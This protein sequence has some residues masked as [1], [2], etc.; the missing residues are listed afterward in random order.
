MGKLLD[1]IKNDQ[2]QISYTPEIFNKEKDFKEFGKYDKGI[3]PSSN[4]DKLRSSNQEILDE[5]T[6]T[7][8][9]GIAKI[10]FAIGKNIAALTD[11]EDFANQD[12]EFGNTLYDTISQKEKELVDENFPVHGSEQQDESL[13]GAKGHGREWLFKGIQDLIGSAGG[14]A[15][16]GYGIGSGLSKGAQLLKA[17]NLGDKAMKGVQAGSVLADAYL[18]NH[19]EGFGIASDVYKNA[20]DLGYTPEKAVGMAEHALNINKIN[21]LLNLTAANTLI[22]SSGLARQKVKDASFKEIMKTGLKESGQEAV[23]ENINTI[24]EKQA[25]KKGLLGSEYNL[26]MPSIIEDSFSKDGIESA[27]LGA[28]GGH[29]QGAFIAGINELNGKNKEQREQF[30]KQKNQIDDLDALLNNEKSQTL[31]GV[32]SNITN[33]SAK[34]NDLQSAQTLG[35]INSE[36]KLKSE[37]VSNLVFENAK[38]GTLDNLENVFDSVVSLNPE[39]G[40]A[41]FGD[42]YKESALE[43]KRQLSEYEKIYNETESIIALKGDFDNK[44]KQSLYEAKVQKNSLEKQ[45]LNLEKERTQLVIS[46]P[47]SDLVKEKEKQIEETRIKLN[48]NLQNQNLILDDKEYKKQNKEQVNNFVNQLNNKSDEIIKSSNEDKLVQQKQKLQEFED[49]QPPYVKARNKIKNQLN[50]TSDIIFSLLKEKK[51]KHKNTKLQIDNQINIYKDKANKLKED[52][53]TIEPLYNT[54]LKANEKEEPIIEKEKEENKDNNVELD[55]NEDFF[56]ET[57]TQ[58]KESVDNLNSKEKSKKLK[59]L[60]KIDTRLQK[61][62]NTAN[63][64]IKKDGTTESV[65]EDLEISEKLLELNANKIEYLNSI[66][67]EPIKEKAQKPKYTEKEITQEQNDIIES[68]NSL[69][70][71]LANIGKEEDIV[72]KNINLETPISL[73]H[74]LNLEET[75]D[76]DNSKQEVNLEFDDN[77]FLDSEDK[78]NNIEETKTQPLFT[79]RLL[80]NINT[81]AIHFNKYQSDENGFV[82]TD[83]NNRV[84]PRQKVLLS[85]T[86]QQGQEVFFKLDTETKEFNN[87]NTKQ[88]NKSNLAFQINPDLLSDELI[89]QLINKEEK[90][91][92]N[93]IENNIPIKIF[94]KDNQGNDIELGYIHDLSYIRNNRVASEEEN[95]EIQKQKLKQI[96]KQ[97]LLNYRNGVVTKGN[98]IEKTR[99]YLITTKDDQGKYIYK[100]LNS[101]EKFPNSPKKHNHPIAF[102]DGSNFKYNDIDNTQVKSIDNIEYYLRSDINANFK[103]CVFL[104]VPTN[105]KGVYHAVFL[106]QP[107]I[108]ELSTNEQNKVLTDIKQAIEV[109]F[110]TFRKKELTQDEIDWKNNFMNGT[111]KN[112]PISADTLKKILSYYLPVRNYSNQKTDDGYFVHV[113]NNGEGSVKIYHGKQNLINDKNSN[114]LVLMS[115]NKIKGTDKAI[116]ENRFN[117]AVK[118]FRINVS[119]SEL[120]KEKNDTYIDHIRNY[121]QTNVHE[122]S[123]G[124]GDTTYFINPMYRY[125]LSNDVQNDIVNKSQDISIDTKT[126]NLLGFNDEDINLSFEDSIDI[127]VKAYQQRIFVNSAIYNVLENWKKNKSLGLNN[128]L[129]EFKSNIKSVIEKEKTEGNIITSDLL[130]KIIDNFDTVYT[131]QIKSELKILGFKIDENNK[132]EE[133]EQENNLNVSSDLN[134]VNEEENNEEL[135]NSGLNDTESDLSRSEFDGDYLFKINTASKLSSMVRSFLY[136]IPEVTK[137]ENGKFKGIPNELKLNSYIPLTNIINELNSIFSNKGSD[138]NNYIK[139]LKE[140]SLLK[141]KPYLEL[142]ANRLEKSSKQLQN[143]FVTQ[144]NK[145]YIEFVGNQE[146]NGINRVFNSNNN[147][148]P[149]QILKQFRTDILNTNSEK[150]ERKELVKNVLDNFNPENLNIYLNYIGINLSPTTIKHLVVNKKYDT[151]K[152]LGFLNKAIDSLKD[153]IELNKENTNEDIDLNSND[154]SFL[155]FANAESEFSKDQTIN[156]FRDGQGKL[157]YSYILPMYITDVLRKINDSSFLTNLAKLPFFTSSKFINKLVNNQRFKDEF[158][159]EFFDSS[160]YYKNEGKKLKDITDKTLEKTKLAFF[161]NNN[162]DNGK[163]FFP[164]MSDKSNMVTLTVPK[165]NK[166]YF[167]VEDKGKIVLDKIVLDE[168]KDLVYSEA[169]RIN[170]ENF[171]NNNGNQSTIDGYKDGNQLFYIFPELNNNKRILNNIKIYPLNLE[172]IQEDVEDFINKKIEDLVN[173][174][175]QYWNDLNLDPLSI[176]VKVLDKLNEKSNNDKNLSR[177]LLAYEYVTNNLLNTHNMFQLFVTDPAIF[178]KPKLD[179]EGNINI[180]KTIDSTWDNVFKRLAALIA[181]GYTLANSENKTFKQVFV[182][183]R[184]NVISSNIEFIKNQFPQYK[185]VYSDLAST[186]AQELITIPEKLYTLY[187]QGKINENKYNELI[188]K[189]NENKEINKNQETSFDN[190]IPL[191]FTKE[192]IDIILQP[193]KPV[194]VQTGIEGQTNNFVYIKSSSF[195]LVPQLVKDLG[196]D[197]IRYSMENTNTDRLVFKSGVKTG[198]TNIFDIFNDEGNFKNTNELI[199]DFATKSANLD[200]SGFKIQQEVPYDENKDEILLGSQLRKLILDV[201]DTFSEEDSKKV[202][203]RIHK[204]NSNILDLSFQQL[205]QELKYNSETGKFEDVSKI[206]QV[207]D[208]LAE[209]RGWNEND[210]E[211]LKTNINNSGFTLPLWASNMSNKI[212]SI[213]TSI[214]NN[215]VFKQKIAGRSYILGSDE[216]WTGKSNEIEYLDS[217]NPNDKL[218]SMRLN[219]DGT[220]S[221]PAQVFI[222]KSLFKSLKGKKQININ[223]LSEEERQLIGYRIPTQGFNSMSAI[224]VVGFLPDYMGDLIIAPADFTAQM[225]SDFD[226]DKLY[227]HSFINNSIEKPETISEQIEKDKF[228]LLNEYWKVLT[229]PLILDKILNPLTTGNLNEIKSKIEKLNKNKSNKNNDIFYNP[230]VQSENLFSGIA[231]KSGIGR[232]SLL[233]TLWSIMNKSFILKNYDGSP[234]SLQF[235]I[236]NEKGDKEIFKVSNLT[237]N[238]KGVT[239]EDKSTIISNWQSASVDNIKELV[240]KTLNYNDFTH[241]AFS[242]LALTIGDN[243]YISYFLTQPIIKEYISEL[244]TIEEDLTDRLKKEAFN[245]VKEKYVNLVTTA[246]IFNFNEPYSKEELF[247]ML[248]VNNQDEKYYQDQLNILEKFDKLDTYGEELNKISQVLSLDTNGVGQSLF[249]LTNKLAL[250]NNFYLD[251]TLLDGKKSLFK[252]TSQGKS[253][254]LSYEVNKMFNQFYIYESPVLKKFKEDYSKLTG[255]RL[256]KKQLKKFINFTKSYIYANWISASSSIG[257][258]NERKR[259]FFDSNNNKSLAKRWLDFKRSDEGQKNKLAKRIYTNIKPEGFPSFVEFNASQVEDYNDLDLVKEIYSMYTYGSSLEKKLINDTIKYMYIN[260]GLQNQNNFIKYVPVDWLINNNLSDFSKVPESNLSDI[261]IKQFIQHNLYSLEDINN[262][263]SEY[264]Y[265]GIKEGEFIGIPEN[266]GKPLQFIKAGNDILQYRDNINSQYIYEKISKLGTKEFTEI[267]PN[268][269]NAISLIR[270]LGNEVEFEQPEITLEDLINQN[271]LTNETIENPNFVPIQL[272][273]YEDKNSKLFTVQSFLKGII[274]NTNTDTFKSIANYLLDIYDNGNIEVKVPDVLFQKDYKNSSGKSVEGS[275][276]SIKNTIGVN[277]TNQEGK[278]RNK[279]I[280]EKVFLHELGHSLTINAWNNIVNRI[281]NKEASQEEIIVHRKIRLLYDRSKELFKDQEVK[282]KYFKLYEKYYGEKKGVVEPFRDDINENSKVKEYLTELLSNKAFQEILSEHTFSTENVNNEIFKI[283]FIKKAKEFINNLLSLFIK[284]NSKVNINESILKDA[285]NT[286]FDLKAIEY[287][288]NNNKEIYNNYSDNILKDI[289]DELDLFKTQN[290]SELV[291]ETDLKAVKEIKEIKNKCK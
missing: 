137:D 186:D 53:N 151:I 201:T 222:T 75:Q 220:K 281:T 123:I 274:N 207:I 111:Y 92:G 12:D 109:Y 255:R 40:K 182:N 189:Y 266:L 209:Q 2:K 79:K 165:I 118:K 102:F 290:I 17:L 36:K 269:E 87:I 175:L 263:F 157:R 139:I 117:E 95:H 32:F 61:A 264:Q 181:P 83:K 128:L 149:K 262:V 142:L 19:A 50:V 34:L 57:F 198:A 272:K 90:S 279:T 147:S 11:W 228:D 153:N 276:N 66:K 195:P 42:D 103:G 44:R 184:K 236:I 247:S 112:V 18:L 193:D 278:E 194:N 270:P 213:L 104:L 115:S 22:R 211:A 54:Y 136:F 277:L 45:I 178:S 62:I 15:A 131:N 154:S 188:N 257:L 243:E 52:L 74:N 200:R 235:G 187:N 4:Q 26:N 5:T 49:S 245:R 214:I 91:I 226:I 108:N 176:D 159:L 280:L 146:T 291:N 133:T 41:K 166:D 84:T 114:I 124:N 20:L 81:I 116:D 158:K 229:N 217:F 224:E 150:A 43:A 196:L 283:S 260:G 93:T 286:F 47:G 145:S 127:N 71:L 156:S 121:L 29:A 72:P 251:E 76:I 161:I 244:K 6:N 179:S 1:I 130:S 9:G 191:V 31:K 85:D 141:N 37:L 227:V 132:I 221:L 265:N 148:L 275:Y 48:E 122:A 215:N 8:I 51:G 46:N 233:S 230:R 288:V 78:V 242:T 58:F 38:V 210:R 7:L 261:I 24:A 271:V 231:G 16:T 13:F 152:K 249:D 284:N 33:T 73:V 248:Q 68:E 169:K 164:V 206:E 21:T 171:N 94:T 25:Y 205:K 240:L 3:L 237:E 241:N 162:L 268:I 27:F 63:F 155:Y 98:I 110:K 232:L 96:K 208:S 199:N 126:N 246:P 250:V 86:I 177:K 289:Q 173:D 223:K 160:R 89:D 252:N 216:G 267:T 14:F 202:I 254:E 183:D 273:G 135:E 100:S 167:I 35:D 163:F 107:K 174:N 56:D 120:I 234:L 256:G 238:R 253:L 28:L 212:E 287:S 144:F 88:A 192:E 225:G 64:R 10:P 80:K 190:E 97:V 106:K 39:E 59:Y 185:K 70:D 55:N 67:N 143:E 134:E 219:K 138:I 77:Q 218:K 259:L 30:K 60:K 82:I 285:L 204:L 239:G 168:L 113:D 65:E 170:Q 23:E 105:E 282:D 129:N 197:N 99:G 119:K 125:E 172:L 101:N 203:N 180:N 140:E 258:L 69:S